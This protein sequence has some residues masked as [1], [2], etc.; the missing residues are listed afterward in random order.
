VADGALVLLKQGD[1]TMTAESHESD[2]AA[3]PLE[4]IIDG[5]CVL[6]VILRS[7]FSQPGVHFF[8][9]GFFSQQL[10]FI[11]HPAG[12]QIAPHV[13]NP[14]PREVVYTQEVLFVRRGGMRV[15]LFRQDQ[16]YV[17]SRTLAAGDVIL[18]AEGGHG[19]EILEDSEIVEVKQGP[20]AGDQDKTRFEGRQ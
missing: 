1:R 7:T 8:S 17:T 15:D 10:G 11:G 12:H 2:A 18:L 5:D 20:Y 19:F 9:P 3:Q 13:H 16:T 6:A 14:A 4:E